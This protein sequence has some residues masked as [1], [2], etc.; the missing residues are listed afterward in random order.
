MRYRKLQSPTNASQLK[1]ILLISYACTAN[2]HTNQLVV[3]SANRILKCSV[4]N[5]AVDSIQVI[6]LLYNV[7]LLC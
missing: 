3:H 2:L 1:V 6:F 7:W 5:N 4:F